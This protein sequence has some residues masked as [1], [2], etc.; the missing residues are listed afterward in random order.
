MPEDASKR[1]PTMDVALEDAGVGLNVSQRQPLSKN[2]VGTRRYF[3]P[4][5]LHANLVQKQ[6]SLR[7]YD[8]LE[9]LNTFLEG[10]G[11]QYSSK[12]DVW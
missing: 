2:C 3:A 9:P 1:N 11:S 8:L 6:D 12:S 4:E 10:N 7:K 5:I